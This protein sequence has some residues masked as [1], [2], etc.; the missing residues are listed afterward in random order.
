MSKKEKIKESIG[1]ARAY[2]IAFLTAIFGV[3]GYAII[4]IDDLST[5]QMLYGVGALAF[6]LVGFAF[7]AKRYLKKSDEL[8]RMR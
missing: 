6:L 1:T 8:G 7:A 3:F 5:K 4:N 2:Q